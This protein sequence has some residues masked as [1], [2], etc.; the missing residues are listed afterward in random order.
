MSNDMNQKR[1]FALPIHATAT[2]KGVFLSALAHLSVRQDFSIFAK[3]G[4]F[5]SEALRR[6]LSPRSLHTNNEVRNHD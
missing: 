5:R 6:S 2:A 4:L 3:A 1:G